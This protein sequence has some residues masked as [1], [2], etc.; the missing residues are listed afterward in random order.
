[1][2]RF[3]PQT[4]AWAIAEQGCT[5]WVAAPTMLTALV[6]MPSVEAFDFYSLRIIVTGGSPVPLSLQQRFQKLAP[7]SQLGEGY[8]MTEILAAG[9]VHTPLAAG[10]RDFAGYP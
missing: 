1:M 4:I 2:T 3:V 5:V 6:H 7:N 9:G 10:K 8:G